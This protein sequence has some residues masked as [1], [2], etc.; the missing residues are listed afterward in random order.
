VR[1]SLELASRVVAAAAGAL[2]VGCGI[3]LYVACARYDA[4]MAKVYDVPVP[5]V[6]RSADPA[7]I[8]RGKHLAESIASCATALCHGVDL[9]GGEPIDLGPLG[10]IAGPNITPALLDPA[11]TDGDLARAIRHGL[12]KEG[13]SL[14]LMPSQDIGWLPDSDVAAIVSYVRATPPVDRASGPVIV[15]MLAKVLDRAYGLPIDVARRIDHSR[16][17]KVPAPQESA[18]YGAFVA[19]GCRQ[20]HGEH[21]S[22]GR[23]PGALP[24]MST[25]LNLTPDSTGLAQWTVDDFDRTMRTGV[26]KNG[27]ALT[28][29]MPVDAWR[30]L[31]DVEMRALWAYL[32]ALPPTRFGNR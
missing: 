1:S 2:L 29:F 24:S 12:N 25:P 31:D 9:G 22:G 5:A 7:V 26:R 13:R 16:V 30:N 20:C 19:R 17:E 10:A 4:S 8:A 18:A 14:R 27:A 28:P 11:L 23:I 3:G 15:H 21:L 6:V 32:R